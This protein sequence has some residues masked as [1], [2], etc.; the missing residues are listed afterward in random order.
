MVCGHVP[1][2]LVRNNT[3]VGPFLRYQ[4]TKTKLAISISAIGGKSLEVVRLSDHGEP[5][6]QRHRLYGPDSA[7][8]I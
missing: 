5:V 8:I 4:A 7:W 1:G 6:R 3:C 2:R